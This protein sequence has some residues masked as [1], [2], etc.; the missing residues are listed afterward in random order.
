M[1]YR[2]KPIT[3]KYYSPTMNK[4][5]LDNRTDLPMTEFILLAKRVIEL[6]KVSN[7]G[8][9]YCYLTSF[10]IDDEEYHVVSDLNEKSDRLTFYKVTDQRSF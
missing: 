4:L 8:S 10:T 3:K 7:N 5:I 1:P 6:G 2:D 9:Q